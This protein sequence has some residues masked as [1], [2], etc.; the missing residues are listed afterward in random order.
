M[1]YFAKIF[2]NLKECSLEFLMRYRTKF[3]DLE[4]GSV[5]FTFSNRGEAICWLI[6]AR[7]TAQQL[8]QHWCQLGRNNIQIE[9][10]VPSNSVVMKYRIQ[11]YGRR[12][13]MDRSISSYQLFETKQDGEWKMQLKIFL[14]F[15]E[16][17]CRF[18]IECQRK[19]DL[20]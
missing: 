9:L 6:E 16:M 4:N 12:L 15:I 18:L 10:M 20:L 17:T 8:H 7:R 14:P 13:K 19:Q 1:S 2:K 11:N 5:H 3:Y